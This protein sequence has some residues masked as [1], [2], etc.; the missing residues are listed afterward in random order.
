MLS[1]FSYYPDFLDAREATRL[2]A[3]IEQLRPS[4]STSSTSGRTTS[5]KRQPPEF[6]LCGAILESNDVVWVAHEVTDVDER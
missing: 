3:S 2:L 5:P 4:M 1:G 6:E